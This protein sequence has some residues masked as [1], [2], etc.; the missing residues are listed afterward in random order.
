MFRN[1]GMLKRWDIY[2][3]L[4]EALYIKAIFHIRGK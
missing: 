3:I 4:L 2:A 1:G